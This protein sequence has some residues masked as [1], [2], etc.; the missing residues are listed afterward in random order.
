MKRCGFVITGVVFLVSC[1][2]GL[3]LADVPSFITYSG[4]LTDG[5]AWGKSEIMALTFRIYDQTEGG[6]PLWEQSFPEV[7]VEDGHFSVILGD[8]INP[9]DN[10][11]LNVTDIFATQ[12]QTWLTVCIG[13]NCTSDDDLMPRQ[14]V[15]SVPYAVKAEKSSKTSTRLG[16]NII[17]ANAVY[18]GNTLDAPGVLSKG[19]FSET[20]TTNGHIKFI[21]PDGAGE[22]EGYRAAKL[23]CEAALISPTAQ[24]CTS[25]QLLLSV[26]VGIVLPD[27]FTMWVSTGVENIYTNQIGKAITSDCL[28]WKN[29]ENSDEYYSYI[30]GAVWS[31]SKSSHT[32]CGNNHP[33]ACCD[34]AVAE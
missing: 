10:T 21:D 17:A 4:R 34:F 8:G 20:G 6:D 30:G 32:Y 11:V 19:S 5:T 13:Q 18:R 15:G 23:A 12:E 33:I 22:V 28:G 3:V 2:P 9:S 31:S 16:P 24:F 1:I 27:N 7:A 14:A 29:S 26:Q 25:Q